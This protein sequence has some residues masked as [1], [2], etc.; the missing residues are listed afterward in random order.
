MYDDAVTNRMHRRAIRIVEFDSLVR[1]E[2]A[3]HRRPETVGLVDERLVT[4]CD[5]A[6]EPRVPRRLR[7]GR[8]R[9]CRWRPRQTQGATE[10]AALHY[11]P[12][13]HPG[14]VMECPEDLH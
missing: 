8:R 13:L 9:D 7:R 1:L 4:E 5:R 3:A 11:S 6:L 12:L 10:R 14:A 2:G